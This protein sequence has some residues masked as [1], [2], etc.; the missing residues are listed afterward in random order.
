[1]H[2]AHGSIFG[3]S[4]R[5]ASGATISGSVVIGN[6]VWIGPNSTISNGVKFDDNA[7]ITIG[8]TVISDVAEN[9][10]VTRYFSVNHNDFIKQ[11]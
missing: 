11:R 7:K 2:I 9:T 10:K 1:V 3:E 5:I 6:N 4:V 8:S